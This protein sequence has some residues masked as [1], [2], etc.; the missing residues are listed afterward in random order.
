[1]RTNGHEDAGISSVFM[2]VEQNR[3]SFCG[4]G[5][6]GRA[7]PLRSGKTRLIGPPFRTARTSSV[8]YWTVNKTEICD[9]Y[10][11]P[12]VSTAITDATRPSRRRWSERR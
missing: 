5:S 3:L 10:R 4:A 9:A 6:T 1:M 8:Y 12:W 2:S 11:R 7:I